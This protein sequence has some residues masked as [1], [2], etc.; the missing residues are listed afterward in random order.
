MDY[1][2]Y[3][4]EELIQILKKWKD[5]SGVSTTI[6]FNYHNGTLTVYSTQCGLLI[7]RMGS[8]ISSYKTELKKCNLGIEN[9]E[10]IEFTVYDI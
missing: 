7:G 10:L 6:K 9:I 5:E 8:L 2:D 3:Y 1:Q 4:Y